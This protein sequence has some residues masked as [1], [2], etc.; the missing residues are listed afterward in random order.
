MGSPKLD[1][2]HLAI[3]S[4]VLGHIRWKD[5]AE[6]LV[7]DDSDLH[8]QGITAKAIRALLR[9]FVLD[10]HSLEFR[11]ETRDEYLAENPDD[12]YWYRAIIPVPGFPHGIFVEVKLVDDDP[13]EPWIEIVSAHRQIP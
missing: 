9:Q 1:L 11:P 4:G 8:G 5:A 3:R 12:P 13:I 6:C 2:V 10:G 7:R